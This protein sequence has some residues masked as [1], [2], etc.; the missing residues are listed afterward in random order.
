M[1]SI[2]SLPAGRREGGICGDLA[3]QPDKQRPESSIVGLVFD[4]KW[5][6]SYFVIIS[7]L[8]LFSSWQY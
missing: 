2:R 4:I 1:T 3:I 8:T 6:E 7:T 5:T